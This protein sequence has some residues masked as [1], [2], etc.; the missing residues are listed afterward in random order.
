MRRTRLLGPALICALAA[1]VAGCAGD[2]AP[3]ATSAPTAPTASSSSDAADASPTRSS[4]PDDAA[5]PSA[6]T[7]PESADPTLDP[8]ASADPGAGS[9]SGESGES[10]EAGT[11]TGGGV[12]SAPGAPTPTGGRYGRLLNADELPGFDADWAWSEFESV[13]REQGLF[14]LCQRFLFSDIGAT[15]VVV[16][17]F[18]AAVAG[19]D[20][21]G[22]GE[23]VATFPDEK[24][25][26]DALSVLQAWA[27]DCEPEDSGVDA[28]VSPWTKVQTADAT[29]YWYAVRV[30]SSSAEESRTERVTAVQRGP[31]LAV[32]RTQIL[33]AEREFPPTQDPA[34]LTA[35]PTA[36]KLGA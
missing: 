29:A 15:E 14:T 19:A 6:S 9:E 2:E 3:E 5:D 20:G 26:R 17:R 1:P 23:T 21:D 7:E 22:A 13:P 12:D 24:Q 32:V 18:D 4:A 11:D 36:S 28:E 34:A 25:A 16:R 35:G 27:E 10:G 8:S 31:R 30:T 33:G